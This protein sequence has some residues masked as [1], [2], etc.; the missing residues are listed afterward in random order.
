M[1]FKDARNVSIEL[2]ERRDYENEGKDDR[3]Y[4]RC[5][6][7]WELD[8]QDYTS[9]KAMKQIFA[10]E[11]KTKTKQPKL[12]FRTPKVG[13]SADFGAEVHIR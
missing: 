13:P 6:T 4:T 10:L 12:S 2:K 9:S 7:T 1:G 3:E 8:P 11:G 5:R